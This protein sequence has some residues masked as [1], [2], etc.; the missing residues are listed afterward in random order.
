MEKESTLKLV[1]ELFEQN[2]LDEI[3]EDLLE[4][5]S[6]HTAFFAHFLHED[7][8]L[9]RSIKYTSKPMHY[10]AL[11]YPPKE[12]CRLGRANLDGQ[13]I[14]YCAIDK[15][16]ALHETGAEPGDRYIISKWI[17]R[18]KLAMNTI[19]YTEKA[20]SLLSKGSSITPPKVTYTGQV[21]KSIYLQENLDYNELLGVMFSKENFINDQSYY[22][23][24]NKIF[25]RLTIGHIQNL[26]NGTIDGLRYPTIRRNGK[27]DCMALYPY[28]V[29]NGVIELADVEFIKIT[30]GSANF[31]YEIIDYT[32]T[33]DS[34]GELMWFNLRK[35]Y[36]H[37]SELDDL[38]F[39]RE[40]NEIICYTIDGELKE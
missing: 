20:Y 13:Q 31:D 37:N 25:R 30:S 36:Q 15:N 32:D 16:T 38:I 35:M 14:F 6:M 27:S 1:T 29:D 33:V 11:I 12:N 5:L 8:F 3:T 7:N 10:S 19:A 39:N 34:K 22:L 4:E 28:V 2:R 40:G 18:H 21:V 23:L 26:N 9:Y 24:T 17:V